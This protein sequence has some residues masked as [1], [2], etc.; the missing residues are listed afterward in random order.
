MKK[1]TGV[2]WR[3]GTG[4]CFQVVAREIALTTGP[5][6]DGWYFEHSGVGGRAELAGRSVKMKKV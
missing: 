1:L 6:V 3:T 4:T 2:A 5:S